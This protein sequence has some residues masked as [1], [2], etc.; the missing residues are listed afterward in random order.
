M[1]TL[2]IRFECQRLLGLRP[3]FLECKANQIGHKAEVVE[4]AVID[5]DG[6]SLLDELVCPTGEIDHIMVAVHGI[7]NEIAQTA[8]SWKDIWSE[9]KTIISGRTVGV[10]GLDMQLEWMSH[11]HKSSFLPWDFDLSDFFN[12]QKLHS[13]FHH[14]WDRAFNTYRRYTLEEAAELVGLPSEPQTLHR[15]ALEDA[16][17]TR[18]ILLAMAGWKVN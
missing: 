7:T 5:S 13:E 9:A 14:D 16:R 2:E 3:L 4:I 1:S 8:S 17:L 18:S 11:S 12:V 10:F 6:S 15:R